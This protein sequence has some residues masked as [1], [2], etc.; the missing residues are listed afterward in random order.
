MGQKTNPISLRININRNFDSCWYKETT[1]GYS[2]FL[3]YDLKIREYLKSLFLFI[4][5]HTGRIHLQFFP[6]KL[7]IHYYFH[8][9]NQ[10]SKKIINNSSQGRIATKSKILEKKSM[11]DLNIQKLN[12]LKSFFHSKDSTQWKMNEIEK[13]TS[14]EVFR[15]S[16]KVNSTSLNS[17]SIEYIQFEYIHKKLSHLF[18]SNLSIQSATQ[19]NTY[20]S[21]DPSNQNNTLRN[22][23]LKLKD[24]NFFHGMKY[25]QQF[26]SIYLAK[27]KDASANMLQNTNP[28]VPFDKGYEVSIHSTEVTKYPDRNCDPSINVLDPSL[29]DKVKNDNNEYWNILNENL[30]IDF[31]GSQS[32]KD[33]STLVHF[34]SYKI[35]Q[36]NYSIRI[37]LLLIFI[38]S[39]KELNSYSQNLLLLIHYFII[40]NYKRFTELK[41]KNSICNPQLRSTTSITNLDRLSTK[42]NINN[43]NCYGNSSQLVPKYQYKQ[44]RTQ[45]SVYKT[46]NLR[47]IESILKNAIH[48]NSFLIPQKVDSHYKNAQFLCEHIVHR[49]QQN[50]SFRQIF[51]QLLLEIKK[52]SY[53]QGI[54]IVCSGRLG[55]VEMAKVESK[56]YGQT[57]LHV[58]SSKI[59]FA[60]GNAYTP[61]GL[62]GVKVWISFQAKRNG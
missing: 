35:L 42:S 51:K 23:I 48:C 3:Q 41:K 58:F 15:Q 6:K 27:S 5:V 33:S 30:K 10:L 7:V 24:L 43:Q 9:T 55:G 20:T 46:K 14:G 52:C 53:I 32:A 21:F 13:F 26:D 12:R 16:R 25:I 50:T 1:N 11:H 19:K 40:Q 62:I 2:Q 31:M 22:H 44:Q 47:H 18:V 54:R 45:F 49:L 61:Y 28:L 8:D 57:S 39:L 17:K 37:L 29:F 38:S 56:K 4:G 59:D 36:Q 34:T 60:V